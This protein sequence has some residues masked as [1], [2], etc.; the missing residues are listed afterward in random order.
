MTVYFNLAQAESAE[1]REEN[2]ADPLPG[3]PELIAAL[4]GWRG[5]Q[6]DAYWDPIHRAE[7]EEQNRLWLTQQCPGCEDGGTGEPCIDHIA[8][9][10][11]CG[12]RATG[13]ECSTCHN[14]IEAE[15]VRSCDV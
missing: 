1:D 13:G 12:K 9:W 14:V 10:C 4:D 5:Q 7:A 6:W 3:D 15:I 2:G 11:Y 8:D